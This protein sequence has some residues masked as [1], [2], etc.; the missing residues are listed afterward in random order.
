MIKFGAV[1]WHTVLSA[2][3]VVVSWENRS[4]HVQKGWE[5]VTLSNYIHCCETPC[6]FMQ[7]KFSTTCQWSKSP[8]SITQQ[9]LQCKWNIRKCNRSTNIITRKTNAI[10]LMSEC[11]LHQ[12]IGLPNPLLSTLTGAS[13]WF[14]TVRS[15]SSHSMC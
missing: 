11:T 14:Q 4:I 9:V 3:F 2:V 10:F 8:N 7:M 13:P 1:N 12:T 6:L 15:F 5:V